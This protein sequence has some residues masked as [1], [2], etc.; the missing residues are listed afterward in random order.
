M[1]HFSKREEFFCLSLFRKK[2]IL[3]ANDESDEDIS[4]NLVLN[5]VC[6]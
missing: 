3:F 4:K 5:S 1:L 6:Y 2:G